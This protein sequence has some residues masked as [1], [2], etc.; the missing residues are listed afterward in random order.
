LEVLVDE[1]HDGQS[2][3]PYILNAIAGVHGQPPYLRP[4]VHIRAGLQKIIALLEAA[5]FLQRLSG[6]THV[7]LGALVLLSDGTE[8]SGV[9]RTLVTFRELDEDLRRWYLE[10]REWPDRAGAYAIQG[11]GAALVERIDGDFWNVVGLPVPLLL[12]L[13]PEVLQT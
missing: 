11:R 8:R 3:L 5:A 13:A 7:V 4:G 9:E 12:R 1:L 10:S 2:R 6:R